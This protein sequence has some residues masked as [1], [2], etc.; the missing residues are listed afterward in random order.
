MSDF[1]LD[2]A[3][4]EMADTIRDT[5]RRFAED[6]LRLL[7]FLLTAVCRW[8]ILAPIHLSLAK[9][10]QWRHLTK[11]LLHFWSLSLEKQFYSLWPALLST[12]ERSRDT[13]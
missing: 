1:G 10:F 12:R 13:K 7:R 11:P 2:F 8:A 5:T 3:L 6:R 9:L 4:G